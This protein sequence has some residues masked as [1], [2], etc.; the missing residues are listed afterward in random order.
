[1][2][3]ASVREK[4]ITS[5]KSLVVEKKFS[6]ITIKDITDGAGIFRATFYNYFQDKYAVFAAILEDELFYFVREL[7]RN[8]MSENALELI[9]RYFYQNKDFCKKA[10]EVDGVNSFKAELRQ[11]LRRSMDIT[12]SKN[13][14][15]LNEDWTEL[16]TMD[17]LLDFL[18]EIFIL[19]LTFILKSDDDNEN[20]S[21]RV[22]LLVNLVNN[23][24]SSFII[25]PDDAE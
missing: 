25:R 4:I 20:V 23:G 1:V 11:Q 16:A 12:I 18:V 13:R 21:A 7:I 17:D 2:K 19:T 5:F 22:D 14:S 15:F 3:E 9:A 10:M 6:N 24:L 8:N